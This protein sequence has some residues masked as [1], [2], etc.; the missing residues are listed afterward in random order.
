MPATSSAPLVAG[1]EPSPDKD[2]VEGIPALGSS[3]KLRY[4]KL[5]IAVGAYSQSKSLFFVG[6]VRSNHRDT[7]FNVPGVKE[8][9]HFLKDVKDARAIRNRILG[10]EAPIWKV[11]L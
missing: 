5:V 8:H 3:Y 7:A 10:C 11:S 4:D 9:A 1:V 2:A 6:D